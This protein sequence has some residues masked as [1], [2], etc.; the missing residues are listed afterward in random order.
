MEKIPAACAMD[1]SIQLEKNLRSKIPGKF[2]QTLNEIGV[3][4]ECWDNEPELKNA[5]YRIFGLISG[6]EKLFLNAIFL[7]LADA[8]RLGDKQVKNGVI[9]LFSRMKRSR[10]GSRRKGGI[11]SKCKLEN[12]MEL[13]RRVKEVFDRGDV[14]E[15]GLALVLFGCWA[16]LAYDCADIRYIVLSSLVSGD[17]IE[18]KAALFAAGCLCELSD[19]FASIFLEILTKLVISSEIPRGIKLAGGRAFGKMWCSSAV[20][21]KAYKTGLKLLL[22]SSEDDFSAVM[23]ISLSRIASRWRLL[24]PDQIQLLTLFLSEERSLHMQATLLKCHWFLLARGVCNFPSATD[25]VHN[26]FGILNQSEYPPTLQVEALKI[27]H[28]ILLFNS[29]IFPCM[30]IPELFIKLLVVFETM[31]HSSNATTRVIAVSILTDLSGKLLGRADIVSSGTGLSLASQMTSFVLDQILLLV[32]TKVGVHQ[33][34]ELEVK[35][36]LNLLFNLVEKHLY[37]RCLVLNNICLFIDKLMNI[38]DKL[39]DIDKSGLSNH[40]FSEAASHVKSLFESKFMLYLSK[41]VVA[42]LEHL[43]ETDADTSQVL[44]G[45]KLQLEN[46]C[47]CSYLGG[48]SCIICCLLL[49]LRATYIWLEEHMSLNKTNLSLPCVDSILQLDI[50]A[51][52]CANKMLEGNSSWSSYKAGKIAACQGAWSTA[53]FV[54]E[55]IKT[56]VQ[57]SSCSCW[58]KS[59]AQ[60][61]ASERQIQLFLSHDQGASNVPCEGNLGERGSVSSRIIYGNYVEILLRTS[62]TLISAGEILA[63]SDMG[64]TISFQKWFLTLRAK[65]LNTIADIMKLFDT[66]LLIQDGS[67]S[68]GFGQLE[69][70]IM[71]PCTTSTQELASLIYSSTRI[72]RQMNKLARE[73]DL[74]SASF[75]GDDRQSLMI[76]SALALR[77]SLMAFAAGFAFTIPNTHSSENLVNFKFGDPEDPFH[78]LVIEDL[79]GRFR[80]DDVTRTNI[81]FLLRSFPKYK[82]CFL[83]RFRTQI[84]NTSSEGRYLHKLCE[85]SIS[86]IVTLQ[87]K[88]TRLQQDGDAVSS[89]IVNDGSQ[90]L[91]NITSKLMLIPFRTPRR[92]FR[93]RPSVSSELFVMNEDG[94]Y[95]DEI[96]VLSGFHLSLNLC[97]QLKNTTAGLRGPLAKVY[98]ILNCK[99][100]SESGEYKGQAHLSG[101]DDDILDLNEKLLRYII[102]V[103]SHELHSKGRASD[104]F[105][106]DEYVCFQLNKRGQGFSTCLLDVSAFPAGSYQIKW[107]SGCIDAGG[108]YW[109]LLPLNAGPLCTVHDI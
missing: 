73:L 60:F 32:K 38:L 31:V 25:T 6:E 18:V 8:F 33:P 49:R 82:S 54:F 74:L 64:H 109:S 19:D 98:C 83:P 36:L 97:L 20:A 63:A 10:S 95:V 99:M 90:L 89:Q 26:L 57:S 4:L 35:S 108:T 53:A 67:R 84:S 88:A 44:D 7:R 22:E 71:L 27:L 52:D 76:V 91:F 1:W 40:E 3:R 92:F 39:L 9:K 69:N 16:E 102:D 65:V 66:I 15:R 106:A 5:E 94:K 47:R 28:K 46:V 103:E 86:E 77:C 29:A 93:F 30:K 72:S 2:I 23:L 24:I 48:Y 79:V 43:G 17:V 34:V 56:V 105:M 55:Q 78:A 101:Q 42:C 51:V 21:D 50:F 85:Y 100:H 14:E 87:N 59:L 41:I 11:L 75:M 96:S 68:H 70:R 107:H 58:L 12:Y 104:C 13:L 61:S 45:L 81:L 37:I 62:K 80:I